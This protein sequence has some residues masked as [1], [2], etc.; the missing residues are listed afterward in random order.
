MLPHVIDEETEIHEGTWQT[1]QSGQRIELGSTREFIYLFFKDF[2]DVDCFLNS[3]YF[4]LKQWIYSIVLVSGAQESDSVIH[5]C[6]FS[7]SFPL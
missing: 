7:Y 1:P 6:I 5:M 4:L 3:F 2:F